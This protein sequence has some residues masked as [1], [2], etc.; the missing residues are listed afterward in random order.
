MRVEETKNIYSTCT[1][2]KEYETEERKKETKEISS[3]KKKGRKQF[4]EDK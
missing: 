4:A 3:K 2:E 1:L